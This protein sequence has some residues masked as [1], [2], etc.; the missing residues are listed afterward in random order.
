[1]TARLFAALVLCLVAGL[2]RAEFAGVVVKVLDGDTVDV[3]VDRTPVRVRLAEIDAPEKRQEFGTWS[4]QLLAG[5]IFR[6]TVVVKETGRVDRGRLI[7]TIYL[8]GRSINRM[9]VAQGGAW[10]YRQYLA[11]RSLLDVEESARTAHA[12]LWRDPRPTP[13]WEWRRENQGQT[14]SPHRYF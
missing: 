10:A 3:L 6:K 8:D 7:G 1:M 9:M 5:A 2:A 11:D 4:K 14:R 12:G 13:P